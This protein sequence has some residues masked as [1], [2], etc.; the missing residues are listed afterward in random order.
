MLLA[1]TLG[2]LMM[3]VGWFS[4]V[5]TSGSMAPHYRPG[6]LV[7]ARPVDAAGLHP[8]QAVLVENPAEPGGLLLHRM[9]RHNADGTLVTKG[10]ANAAEDTAAV[11]ATAVRALPRWRVRYIALPRLWVREG[12]YV[13]LVLTGAALAALAVVAASSTAPGRRLPPGDRFE[14][15]FRGLRERLPSAFAAVSILA[16]PLLIRL[17]A[18][19]AVYVSTSSTASD[20]FTTGTVTFGANSPAGAIITATGATPGSYERRCVRVSYTGSLPALVRLYVP[21]GGITGTGLA[22]YL[23]LQIRS[24][25]GTAANCSD[26][27]AATNDYNGTGYN[28]AG[29]R[30]LTKTLATLGTDYATGAG[31]WNAASGT[32]RTYEVFWMLLPNNDAASLNVTFTLTWEGRS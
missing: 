8:G 2:P 19:E 20:S 11:P 1:A 18:V 3:S 30:D 13:P 10:D 31:G 16:V 27:T 15:E 29:L 22:P 4:V 17:P 12:A 6:D 14:P 25:T 9:I 32:T 26:F 23:A 21:A 5:V 24:G 7:V 28:A